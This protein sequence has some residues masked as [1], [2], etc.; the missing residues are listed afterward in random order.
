MVLV[1]AERRERER[2]REWA[3]RSPEG[4]RETNGERR[5]DPGEYD[6]ERKRARVV[7]A[8]EG[9]RKV[10]KGCEGDDTIKEKQHERG[11]QD[12]EIEEERRERK[13]EME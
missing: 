12:G 11:I 13:N 3:R 4:W 6:R 2:R 10:S 5:R 9:V 7:V 8:N 1:L